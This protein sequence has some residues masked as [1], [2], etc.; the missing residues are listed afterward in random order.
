MGGKFCTGCIDADSMLH[1]ELQL[2]WDQY[3]VFKAKN[4][5][6]SDQVYCAKGESLSYTSRLSVSKWE[7]ASLG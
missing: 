5:F 4:V 6:F 3:G 1:L 2:A 7:G